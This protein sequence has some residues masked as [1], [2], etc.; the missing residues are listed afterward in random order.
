MGGGGCYRRPKVC[1][2]YT[3]HEQANYVTLQK[4][5]LTAQLTIARDKT[6][7]LPKW[8]CAHVNDIRQ[9]GQQQV[10]QETAASINSQ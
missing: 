8:P 10:P 3:L 7:Q 1:H 6:L 9:T 2:S 5:V 4:N